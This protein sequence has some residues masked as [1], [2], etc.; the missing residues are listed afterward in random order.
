M[1]TIL[2][3]LLLGAVQGFTE[4][5]PVSSSGHLVL[6]QRLMGLPGEMVY[7][8]ITMHVATLLAVLLV[9]RKEAFDLVRHP[10]SRRTLQLVASCIPAVVI[11]LAFKAFV[12]SA[13]GGDWLAYGFIATAA[14]IAAGELVAKRA[15][16]KPFVTL[17]RPF[18]TSSAL[19]M[20]VA[21]GLA[22]LPGISRS[23][24]TLCTGLLCGETREAAT[25]FSFLMSIP[26]ILGSA[27][28]GL[29]DTRG[30]ALPF[31]TLTTLT[32]FAAAFLTGLASVHFMLR[33]VAKR[34]LWGFAGYLCVLAAV[35]F[36]V[37]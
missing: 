1:I 30:G 31:D 11:V 6:L 35:T 3:A 7:L 16:R 14:L 20:G 4:F 17:D 2:Q 29:I 21:Q 25:K 37:L 27:V 34:R 36:F 13:F 26:I 12:L 22:V 15:R 32:A 19:L 24:A 10:L 9:L 5:L 33:L 18:R 28:M 23:G 8:D